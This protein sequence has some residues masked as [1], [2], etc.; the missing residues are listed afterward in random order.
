MLT[1][2]YV[3]RH[4]PVTLPCLPI[5][6]LGSS[7]P[8]SQ[9][10]PLLSAN[11]SVLLALS[12]SALILFSPPSLISELRRVKNVSPWIARDVQNFEKC[13]ADTMLQE[14]LA[15][16]TGPSQN[17]S[18]NEK[19]KLLETALNA[20]LPICNAGA[21]AQEIKGHL[22]NFCDT[23]L[24]PL[25]YAPF[26]KAAN[27]ALRELSR[28][29]VQGIPAFKVDDK[30]NVLLHVN[31][32]MPIYQD[33]RD[34]QSERKPDVVVVSHQTALGTK[35][36]ETQESQVLTEMACKS[37]KDNFQWTDVR[38]TLEFKRTRK[39]LTHPPSVYKIDYVVP[40]PSAQYMEYRKDTNG[41][42][43]PTGSTPATGSAQTPHEASNELRPSSQLSRGVK[44][45]RGGNNEDRTEEDD[46]T[47]PPPIVQ[48]GLYVAE[49][50]AAHIARQH[51]ISFIVNN[52]YIYIWFCDRE[53][54]IQG[55]AI[56]FLQDLPRWLV[57]LLI[58]QR[59][60]YEQWG[61]NRVFEPEP[62]FSGK[63]MI[64]DDQIDLELDVKSKER[65]THFGIRGRATTVFPVKSEALSDRQRDPRFPNE[66]SELVAKLYWPEETRQSEPDI[67][68]EVYKIAQTDPD[69]RGHV[70]ELVW[71]HEFKE[72]STS[73][74][75]VALGL[76][77]AEQAEQGSR[78]LY[79]IV[80]RKLIPIT[81]LSGDEFLAAWWQV[82]KCHRALW[83]GGVLHRDVSPSNLMVYRLRGQFIGVLN[84]Y[85]LSSF[86]RDGPRGLERTGTLPFMAKDLLMPEATAGKVEHVYAHDAESLIWVLTWVCLRYEGGHLLSTNRP[87]EDWLKSDAPMCADKKG[88]F[89]TGGI[90]NV[91]PSGSH[92]KSWDLVERCF[93]GIHSIYLPSG[94]RELSDESAFQLLLEGPMLE[95]ESRRRTYS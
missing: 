86:K 13:K 47:K 56:N 26:V 22:T 91:R 12:A 1:P 11:T 2:P 78:V 69:V 16:C 82:V 38:S 7:P 61:L 25:T 6:R 72:T 35:A 85:D 90:R 21:V 20:V 14:L 53:T 80:F 8:H 67:L 49:M 66:S 18:V 33:H 39:S 23:N 60:G 63:V 65:V 83:K 89:L 19:S 29:N 10:V 31:D 40:S 71:F 52:D 34:K 77:D 24:E 87:L 36:H 43:K 17:L 95:H 46:P 62:G 4:L 79:I 93:D 54:T 30:T 27:C 88:G 41:P 42:A 15:R 94:Y 50:F 84:D 58:M 92:K 48:N 76:K 28:V 45:K 59:M 64:E 32:P 73:K 70:P 75:R 37:P 44:R 57:L 68:K 55:A 5:R 9:S 3:T 74:I 81:T 51:V